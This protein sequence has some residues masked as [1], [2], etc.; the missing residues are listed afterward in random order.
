MA[1]LLLGALPCAAAEVF[2]V[3][4]ADPYIELHTGPGRGYPIFHVIDRGGEIGV[5]RRRTDWFQ[6]RAVNGVEG[7]VHRDQLTQTLTP[8]GNKTE[9]PEPGIGDFSRRRWEFGAMGGDFSGSSTITGYTGYVFTE[10]L[11]AELSLTQALGRYS[12]NWLLGA[13][14]IHQ[15]FP[16][17]RISPYFTLG[18][19]LLRTDPAATLVTT[20]DRT[21]TIADA[22]IGIRAYLSRR[23]ILR[24][25]YKNHVVFMDTNDNEEINQ[26]QAGIGFFF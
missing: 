10:T 25:E 1:L 26:W 13:H 19:G 2:Q 15:P 20:D 3:Q 14:L 7:W 24:L 22:G 17:W 9:L 6:V 5:L 8:D 12:S 21:Q 11:S 23:F 4:V 16:E 18:A